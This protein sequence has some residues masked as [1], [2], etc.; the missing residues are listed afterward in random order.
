M[1]IGVIGTINRDS[2]RLP[3]GTEKEG[4]GGI[5]YNLITLSHLVGKKAQVFPVCNV[6]GDCYAAVLSILEN[7]RG[8]R[9]DY[10]KRVAEKNNHCF[11]TYIDHENKR[12][13]LKGGVRRLKYDDVRPLL[14]C[15]IVLMNYISGRDIY[16]RSLEKLRRNF[17]GRIYVDVH[18][19]TLG[20]KKDGSRFLRTPPNWPAVVRIGDYIQMNRLELSILTEDRRAGNW[21]KPGLILALKRLKAVLL[22]N[23]INISRKVFVITDGI[24]GCHL[25]HYSARKSAFQHIPVRR[26]ARQIDV[27]GCGDCFSAGFIASLISCSDLR[28]CAVSGNR[29]GRS[30]IRNTGKIYS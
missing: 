27:T 15:D 23:E 16:L 1:K 6:G 10:V 4:W 11:L 7:L 17:R 26:A 20:I 30:R 13:I 8:V 19:L 9:T 22:R 12:E 28:S 21:D 29:A 25:S 18:S 14:D 3:D 5:L 2:I 24:R